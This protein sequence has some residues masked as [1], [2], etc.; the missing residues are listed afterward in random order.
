MNTLAKLLSVSVIGL[1][2]STAMAQTT[3]SL[4]YLI[5]DQE[6]LDN[7]LNQFDRSTVSLAHVNAGDWGRIV[8]VGVVDN[9]E[10]SSGYSGPAN[11]G[12]D[13]QTYKLLFK[14]DIKTGIDNLNYM[15]VDSA[16]YNVNG[17]ENNM[18]FGLSYD[19]NAWN[20]K[21]HFAAG[22]MYSS[23]SNAWGTDFQGKWGGY[24][25]RIQF[26]KPVTDKIA[27]SAI[28]TGMLDR[29][30]EHADIM[31]GGVGEM[32]G[33]K[34]GYSAKLTLSYAFTKK[35]KGGASLLHNSAWYGYK[36]EAN[37]FELS[38]SYSF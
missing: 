2:S 32:N 34:N 26:N 36:D 30:Q 11:H 1:C 35:L 37:I 19:L 14:G 29:S 3:V 18:A 15:V 4:G 25:T 27:V 9:I 5:H 38:A 12:E 6:S 21:W 28:Y 13:W 22:Y 31:Y 16:Y 17:Y 10:K 23:G 20:A 24:Y 8:T 33:D 7:N